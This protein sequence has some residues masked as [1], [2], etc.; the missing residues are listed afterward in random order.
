[1]NCYFVANPQSRYYET[2]TFQHIMQH[3]ATGGVQQGLKMKQSN[4]YLIMT[5]EH[6]RNLREARFILESI[7]KEV[8]PP[9]ENPMQESI[10]SI[11]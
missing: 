9:A 5:R 10:T 2:E 11:L 3:I 6:V 1:M 4:Q 7:Q 8:K